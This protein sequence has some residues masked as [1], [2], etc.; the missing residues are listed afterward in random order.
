MAAELILYNYYRS[1][2]SYRVRIALHHKGIPFEYRAVH[3]L[4]NGG[5]Q[6]QEAY[7]KI[8]PLGEVPTLVHGDKA[9]GQSFAILEY[10]EEVFP[11]NALLPKDPW[12]RGRI[13][14]FCENINS[15]IHPLNNLKVQ[16]YLAEK[17]HYSQE[18]KEEWIALWSHQGLKSL[19]KMV[20][21]ESFC[22]GS[23]VSLADVFLIP[24]LFSAQRF[25]VDLTPYP[26]L[27]KIN[28]F[29]LNLEAFKKA[30]PSQ[31]PDS[32]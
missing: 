25:K 31:Q 29:C 23:Q 18:Q 14:Q 27:R 8:N 5:E 12:A 9:I 16:Q 26:K 22:F 3:L 6:H 32:E 15:F 11:Q 4:K 19:E 20:E 30:H 21:G 24:Q 10:L 13:R 1:S 2:T 17:H 7:R 28:D